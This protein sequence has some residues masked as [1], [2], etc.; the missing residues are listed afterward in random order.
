MAGKFRDIANQLETEFISGSPKKP[1][2]TE[3][4]IT[5]AKWRKA[6]TCTKGF[7]KEAYRITMKSFFD[8]VLN[9]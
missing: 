7:V 1:A 2:E 3:Q 8:S 5:P 6:W 4:D 9:K